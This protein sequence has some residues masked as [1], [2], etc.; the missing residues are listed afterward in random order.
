[1]FKRDGDNGVDYF[2]QF[3]VLTT[4]SVHWQCSWRN[5]RY[6][7]YTG[8][9]KASIS[10]CVRLASSH[11]MTCKAR[12]NHLDCV[13]SLVATPEAD[14]GQLGCIEGSSKKQ[15]VA[16]KHAVSEIVTL[17]HH[18]YHSHCSYIHLYIYMKNGFHYCIPLIYIIYLVR[19]RRCK[20]V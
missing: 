16:V 2:T 14:R 4:G 18:T 5:S 3:N 12:V 20:S 13:Q 7:Q 9:N 17:A 6:L 11:S 15:L 19:N 10:S 8:S 1:M